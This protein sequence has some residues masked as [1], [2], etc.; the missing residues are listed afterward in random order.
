MRQTKLQAAQWLPS[1]IS[2]RHVIIS[3]ERYPWS[4]YCGDAAFPSLHEGSGIIPHFLHLLHPTLN[5][6][7]SHWA[8]I[9]HMKAL[10]RL[11]AVGRDRAYFG[12]LRLLGD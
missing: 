1:S 7:V 8:P 9:Y 11:Y 6:R 4:L 10:Y 2:F 12:I 3:L 5:L